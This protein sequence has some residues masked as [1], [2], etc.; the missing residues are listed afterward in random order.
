MTLYISVDTLEAKFDLQRRQAVAIMK[1]I[2][3]SKVAVFKTGRKGWPSRL[4]APNAK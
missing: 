2:A 4:Q 3:A 1:E